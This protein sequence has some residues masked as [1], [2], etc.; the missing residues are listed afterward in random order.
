MNIE[1]NKRM[2]KLLNPRIDTTFKALFT[3]NTEE[4]RS[5]LKAFIEAV[6]NRKID[7]VNLVPSNIPY[8]FFNQR[9]INYDILCKFEDGKFANIEM[10]AFNQNYDYG[11]RAEYYVARLQSTF[12]KKGDNWKTVPQVYQINVANFIYP[13][14][15]NKNSSDSIV[16]YF[17]MRTK[18]GRELANK[19]N[20]ILIELPKVEKLL[21]NIKDNTALENW[22][23]FFRYADD[24]TKM[25]IIKKIIDKEEGIMKAQQSLASISEDEILWAQQFMQD[26]YESDK[27]S[28]MD[29][30][31]EMED[32]I[33]TMENNVKIKE[34]AIK[35]KEKDIKIRE[36]DVKTMENAIKSR[37]SDI[38]FRESDIKFRESDIK[39][40]E[41]KINNKEIE[42]EK[43][44]NK[45]IEQGLKEGLNKGR[46]EGILEGQEKLKKLITK[47]LVNSG[48]SEDEIQKLL[49][50]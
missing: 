26:V 42:L 29:Y 49:D 27:T 9:G 36:N 32:K 8:E 4:S 2:G 38:K 50:V 34:N 3:S 20:I 46:M 40:R 5:A 21:D 1:L 23:I 14:K 10:Q 22:A 6:I 37:E 48:F 33:K 47:K 19:M 24:V 30:Y 31:K 35:I 18:D 7:A 45:L 16:S 15:G 28:R 13:Q 41:S 44:Q 12:F 39:S 43:K 17:T 11:D 25:E